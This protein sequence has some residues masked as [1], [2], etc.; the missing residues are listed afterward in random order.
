[1]N[2]EFVGGLDII[3]EL[4]AGGD[5]KTELGIDQL[6][7]P[8]AAPSSLDEKL[9]KLINTGTV[10]LFMKGSPDAPKCT[11]FVCFPVDQIV[12]DSE[13]FVWCDTHSLD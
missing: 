10:M 8:P 11:S 7:L 9:K 3:K 6:I 4:A 13:V 12:T 1:M 5:I 2:G